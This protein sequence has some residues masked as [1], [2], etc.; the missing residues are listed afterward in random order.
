MIVPE[1]LALKKD[2]KFSFISILLLFTIISLIIYLAIN[3]LILLF[4][5]V[6]SLFSIWLAYFYPVIT[7]ILLIIFGQVIQFELAKVIQS[8][9]GLPVGDF[10]L[11]FSDPIILGIIVT[12]FIKLI[13]AIASIK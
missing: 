2:N 13:I 9:S 12:L 10:N 3:N 1:N 11:R 8:F 5:I 7:I 4:V 6:S